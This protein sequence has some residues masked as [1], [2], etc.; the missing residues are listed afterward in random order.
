MTIVNADAK[1]LEVFCAAYLS[2]DPLMIKELK[3]G[4]DMHTAN[5]KAFGL[6]SRLIAKILMFRILYGGS[7]YSFANDPDFS[8]VSSSEKFWNKKIEAFYEKY[9]VLKQ[10]HI[11]IVQEVMSTGRLVMPTGRIYTFELKRDYRG[12]LKAPETTIKNFPVQGFGADMMAIARVSFA[13]RFKA[14]GIE[15]IMVN[16][17]HDSIVCDVADKYVDDVVQIFH[18]V[19]RDLP[20]NFEKMFK[21]KFDLPMTVEVGVGL[22]FKELVEVKYEN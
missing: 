21:V 14:S 7:G 2:Q 4:L 17:V 16:T 15:G 20:A 19:F 3:E 13:R 8:E 9:K 12:E 1:A 22:N 5:Q 18:E 11:K 10:W 6:P